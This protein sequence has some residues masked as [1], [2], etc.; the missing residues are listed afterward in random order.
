[1]RSDEVLFPAKPTLYAKSKLLLRFKRLWLIK[2]YEQLSECLFVLDAVLFAKSLIESGC[3]AGRQSNAVIVQQIEEELAQNQATSFFSLT[4]TYS[5]RYRGRS[6]S[7]LLSC[8]KL[9]G[10]GQDPS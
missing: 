2:V 7:V 5:H 4:E 1:M 8:G 9:S 3:N 10:L 6:S